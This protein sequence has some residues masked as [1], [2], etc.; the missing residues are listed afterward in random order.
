MRLG[1]E[2]G[3]KGKDLVPVLGL[4]TAE[5]ENGAAGKKIATGK[6]EVVQRDN[7]VG[8]VVDN[9]L[10]NLPGQR[11]RWGHSETARRSE[12]RKDTREHSG[13]DQGRQ[14]A[15]LPVVTALLSVD[16]GL[17]WQPRGRQGS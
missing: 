6:G 3:A 12:M 15:V 5:E 4:N 7:V 17:L 10:N 11:R 8:R 13:K 14:S 16:T 1:L 2:E 9:P